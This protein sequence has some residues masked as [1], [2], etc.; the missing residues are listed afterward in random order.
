[1]KKLW[2]GALCTVVLL[3]VAVVPAFAWGFNVIPSSQCVAGET[4]GNLH[5]TA[6]VQ[7]SG[8]TLSGITVDGIGVGTGVPMDVPASP[9]SHTVVAT[10]SKIVHH[11]ASYGSWSGWSFSRYDYWPYGTPASTSTEEFRR[12]DW[13]WSEGA[14]KIEHRTRTYTPA[15]DETVTYS[16][17]L[18]KTVAPLNCYVPCSVQYSGDV[19]YGTPVDVGEPIFAGPWTDNGNG[20]FTQQGTQATSI[21]WSQPYTDSHTGEVCSTHTGFVPGSRPVER[22]KDGSVLVTSTNTCV[23]WFEARNYLDPDGD[24]VLHEQDG[25][26]WTNPFVLETTTDK[27]GTT[28]NEPED[29]QGKHTT[30]VWSKV[31]CAGFSFGYV[32]DGQ[33]VIVGSDTWKDPYSPEAMAFVVDVPVKGG[34]LYPDGTHFSLIL[35]KP[36]ECLQCR[37]TKLYP[38]A[39]Y[40]D[41]GAPSTYWKGGT[42]EVIHPE[43]ETPS[44]DRVTKL[45]SLCPGQTAD[46]LGY[47]YNGT[48][49]FYDGWV[50]RM[51]CYGK[52]PT[53]WYNGEQIPASQVRSEFDN[54]GNR[55]SGCYV[56]CK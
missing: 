15:Y 25:G 9:G 10:W 30:S 32:L 11:D 49:E 56:G 36:T 54:H 50:Y 17:T 55:I 2:L 4:V 8:Y 6:D 44:A 43:G 26:Y 18:T 48:T 40:L 51:D 16:E 33:S 21:P 23:G 7:S 45:C 12:G 22:I 35:S 41:V 13:S 31:D 47:T 20:T 38:M 19:T 42:C 29:C 5:I 24:Q 3:A 37:I 53:Y 27:F 46:G 52:E 1:M 14:Y 34:E 39:S 28:F